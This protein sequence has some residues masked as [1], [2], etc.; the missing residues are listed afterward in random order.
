MAKSRT[1]VNFEPLP[2]VLSTSMLPPMSSTMFLA[3]AMPRPVPWTLFV[4]EDSA[5]ENG[6]K[7]Y[8]RNSSSMPM[9]VSVTSK[10]KRA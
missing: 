8:L 5:R 9:P 1:T 2:G 4:P 6:S 3:M 10:S 7:M